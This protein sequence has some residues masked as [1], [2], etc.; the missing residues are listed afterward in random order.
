[1]TAKERIEFEEWASA[2]GLPI[3]WLCEC[4]FYDA[5]A[6]EQAWQAWQASRAALV[7]ELPDWS[8]YDTPRQA[9]DACEQRL[10]ERGIGVSK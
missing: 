1:M 5:R 6:T 3:T 10:T 2:D 7:V 4:G 9:I 8:E